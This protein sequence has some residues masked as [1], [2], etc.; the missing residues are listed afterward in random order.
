MDISPELLASNEKIDSLIDRIK[1]IASRRHVLDPL[2]GEVRYYA[3]QD[4]NY[5]DTF[6][7]GCTV[8]EIDFARELC[9][10]LGVAY[11]VPES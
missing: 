7:E 10:L 9:G 11:D 8:G 5:D 2:E 6:E 3:G 4:G 1:F